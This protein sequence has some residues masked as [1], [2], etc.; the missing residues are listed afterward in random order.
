LLLVACV[1]FAASIVG[2]VSGYGVGLILPPVL[3]PVVGVAGVIPVMAVAMAMTNGS[4][5]LAFHRELDFK[6]M[7]LVAA[8]MAPFC[9]AS[10][11]VYTLLPE[12][13]IAAILGAFLIVSIPV[14]RKLS[15]TGW[16]LS[17]RG[18]IAGG[19]I[20]GALVGAMTGVGPLLLS[21]MM[22]LGLRGGGLIG[23]EAAVSMTGSLIKA[24]VF[25]NRAALD[26]ELALAG[27]LIGLATVPGAFVAKW[28]LARFSPRI[29]LAL[30]DALVIFGGASFLW[31]AWTG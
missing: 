7:A 27:L 19:A 26:L 4:R 16:K 17:P 28:L 15:A 21:I 30:M 29:H 18:A 23:S 20:Y 13:A 25:G 11:Y 3:A 14:R 1:A 12:R 2:G 5:V 10:A 22:G 6:A 24:S 8:G 9:L 31:R